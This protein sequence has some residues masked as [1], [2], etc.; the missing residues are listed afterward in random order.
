MAFF[1]PIVIGIVVLG[2][3]ALV[4]EAGGVQV[5]VG[6]PE[7]YFGGE[8]GDS[9]DIPIDIPLPEEA[10]AALGGL[11]LLGALILGATLL[12]GRK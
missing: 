8:D 7:G 3:A 2:V 9:F 1:V 5:Q 4:L 10:K 11:L 12:K 6:R